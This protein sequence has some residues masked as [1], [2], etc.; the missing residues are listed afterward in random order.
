MQ[1]KMFLA[2]GTPVRATV[3]VQNWVLDCRFQPG[4]AQPGAQLGAHELTHVVQQGVAV[5]GWD[6]AKKQPIIGPRTVRPGFRAPGATRQLLPEVD[7]EVLVSFECA[8]P[9]AAAIVFN[10]KEFTLSKSVPWQAQ[11]R[12]DAGMIREGNYRIVVQ[13]RNGIQP[14]ELA[15][16]LAQDPALRHGVQLFPIG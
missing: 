12:G 8:T 11:T 13:R 3:V 6:I 9:R 16:A 14:L 4:R 1:Y 5:R 2:S 10:P 7:D 15:L